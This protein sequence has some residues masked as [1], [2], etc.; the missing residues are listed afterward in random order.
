MASASKIKAKANEEVQLQLLYGDDS[1]FK[2][3]ESHLFNEVYLRRDLPEKHADKWQKTEDVAFQHF[4]NTLRNLASEY[5]D[6]E[7]ELLNWSETET[8]N[9]WVKHVLHAL[10]WS[11]N[12]TGVQNPF[13]EETSFRYEGK[14]YRT[15]IL[16]VDHPKEKQY[17]NQSKGD[18][19]I[20]EAR[21]SVIM[22]VEVKYWQ[23]LEEF[24]Q[25]RKE[26]KNRQDIEADDLE[27]T[28][29]PNEQTVQYM[30][31]LKKNWGI[32]TDGARW[33]LFNSEL[34]SE[35]ANRYY[36]F[37]LFSLVQSMNTEVTESDRREVQEAAKYFYHFFSKGTFYSQDVGEE[38]FVGEVLRYSKKY[39]NKVE[40][41]LKSR[42]VKAMNI[43]CNG[44]FRS[45]RDRGVSTELAN[46]RNVAESTLFNILFI[47]S[48]E[49]RGVLPMNSTDYRK[50][51]LSNTVD[52]I[53]RFDPDKEDLL[54]VRELDRAFKRGNGNSFSYDPK[55]TELHDRILRLTMVIH[56]GNSGKDEFGFEIS[57]FKESVFSKDEWAFIR[58]AKLANDDWAKILF[59]LGYAESESM[60]RK[61][62]QIPYSYFTPRQLG[63]IYESFLEFKIEKADE[64]LVFEKGQW[65]KV[66][67]NSARYRN[68]SLPI[69]KK[70]ELF[71]SPDNE[72]RK[73][74]GSYY[75]PDYIVKFIVADT[76]N[77]IV[78]K[79]KSHEILKLRICDPAMGSGHFL[80]AVLNFL[81]NI[82]LKAT[83]EEGVVE[84]SSIAEVKRSILNS[85]IYGVDI[86]SRAV[87]LAQMSLWLESANLN[88][89]LERLE[90]QLMC[91]DSLECSSEFSWR[92]SFPSVFRNGGFDAVVGNPPYVRNEYLKSYKSLL[93]QKSK[94]YDGNN[95][96]YAYFVEKGMDLLNPSGRF[97][98]II[99]N[100]WMRSE[101][102][103]HLRKFVASSG[104]EL[105]L[106]FGDLEIFKGIA[107]YPCILILNN[108][109]PSKQFS[110]AK[111]DR[112]EEQ[113]FKEYQRSKTSMADYNYLSEPIWTSF[114]K[115]TRSLLDH[116][117]KKSLSLETVLK[118]ETYSG[119]KTGLTEVYVIEKSLAD[120]LISQH[121]SAKE[122][123]KP[124]LM[125]KDLK[126]YKQPKPDKYILFLPKGWTKGRNT[127]NL[128]AAV[129]MKK[130][131]PSIFEYLNENAVSLKK[132]S[133]QGDYWWELRACDYYDVFEGP[134]ISYLMFQTKPTFTYDN[135]GIYTNNAIWSFRVNDMF[136]LGLLNSKIGWFLISNF[137]TQIQGGYQTA[138][139]Y[140][141]RIPV[142]DYSKESGNQGKVRQKVESLVEKV[143]A[144]KTDTAKIEN[145]IDGL[146]YEYFDLSKS[147]IQFIGCAYDDPKQL[148]A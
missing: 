15:D 42:F 135:G 79:M 70:G 17:I 120:R 102:G 36:E 89:K 63:S 76:L 67:L 64:N 43:A 54:N 21:N 12:C 108:K 136:L 113:S 39:V 95:D 20:V 2:Y 117:K 105:L 13:L 45:A 65:K 73:I 40:E 16:I 110:F 44:L 81:T 4:I 47:K 26:E 137:C 139:K 121:K 97:G 22:P 58:S 68:T 34:S 82:Y 145:S 30:E 57:G 14:T 35:D 123:L 115:E 85:C 87:K 103:E 147:Q 27:R 28:A 98:M 80:V 148:A 23:R 104:L 31:I 106:D 90:D 50:I 62:Q 37:N 29:T 144:E 124:F 140:M 138:Y 96:L 75:T 100:K 48:L 83:Y 66:D 114:D 56:G 25:G 107:A 18:E 32:L 53:E 72:D 129:F 55:G 93:Q 69:A 71:F 99:T 91:G 5:K 59:Q 125:G 109:G 146:L 41:D 60:A 118:G 52:K 11:N 7:K 3:W 24:R 86:N 132:R 92:K 141:S 46:I 127:S 119:I 142:P 8:I 61:Y 116:L 33:R 19:K 1:R 143:L 131:Y 51:S 122:V 134:K 6:R 49:S 77:P 88:Q 133:D 74:S 101:Y 111:L 84:K 112:I 9:S 130:N 126:R 78:A 38:S 10:G 94:I 128:D